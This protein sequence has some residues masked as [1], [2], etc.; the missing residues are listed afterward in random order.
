MPDFIRGLFR[1]N[2]FESLEECINGCERQGGLITCA[3]GLVDKMLQ[4]PD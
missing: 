2:I 4:M 3:D 1:R